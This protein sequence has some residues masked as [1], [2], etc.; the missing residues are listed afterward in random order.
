LSEPVHRIK[1]GRAF[2]TVP[3]RDIDAAL[4]FYRDVLGF[5]KVFE[6]GDPV[7][8]VILKKDDARVDLTLNRKHKASTQNVMFMNVDDASS[9]YDICFR[10]GVRIVKKIREAEYGLRTFVLADPDGNRIDIGQPIQRERI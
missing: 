8:F 10:N 1:Y 2:P 6:N 9:L 7:G 5:Q 4:K 3:V